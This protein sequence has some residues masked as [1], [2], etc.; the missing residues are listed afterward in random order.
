MVRTVANLM[1]AL[2]GII[3]LGLITR[4]SLS[5]LFMTAFIYLMAVDGFEWHLTFKAMLFV[6]MVLGDL[7]LFFS[8]GDLP[9]KIYAAIGL[10]SSVLW[11]ILGLNMAYELFSGPPPETI[12]WFVV[13]IIF[14]IFIC[15]VP[16]LIFCLLLLIPPTRKILEQESKRSN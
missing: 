13:A 16:I 11:I 15:A 1:Y 3:G 7:P 14:S 12:Y 10:V 2:V 8:R 5:M 4:M 6:F 9:K